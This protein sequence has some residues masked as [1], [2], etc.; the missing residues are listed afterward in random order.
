MGFILESPSAQLPQMRRHQRGVLRPF[1]LFADSN[2]QGASPR[3]MPC[4]PVYLAAQQK[5][6]AVLEGRQAF[7]M[8]ILRLRACGQ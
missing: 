6:Q 8:Y 4:L 1:F 2:A 3:Q 7:L 5:A